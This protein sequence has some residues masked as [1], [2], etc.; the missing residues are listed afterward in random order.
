ML[1]KLKSMQ[2]LP[3]INKI[4]ETYKS[5][6]DINNHLEKRQRYS[7]GASLENS[8][9]SLLQE[10]IMAKNSPKSLK[11]TYLIKASSHLEIST[12]KLRLFLELNLIN[13][14]KIFQTQNKLSEIGRMLGGW[15]KSLNT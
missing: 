9:M 12:L 4:Y 3:I 5:T 1:D 8:I 7:L 10:I 2:E 14:T 6:I 13:E 15:L 11:A